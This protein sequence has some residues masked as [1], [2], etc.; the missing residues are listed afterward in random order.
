VR[1]TP[2][3][4]FAPSAA[5]DPAVNGGSGYFDGSGDSLSV[6]SNAAF[7]FGTGN[8]SIEVW[9]YPT[10]LPNA[11]QTIVTTCDNESNA[12]GIGIYARTTRELQ[13]FDFVSNTVLF[14]TSGYDLQLN[15]WT[16]IC[17]T[18]SG[19]TVTLYK[20]G[21]SFGTVTRTSNY[22][23]S[24]P[25]RIGMDENLQ[26]FF[27]YISNVRI[28][29]GSA[30]APTMSAPL[31]PITNTS[32]LCN[33]TNAGIFDN[34]GKNVLETVGNAQIDT[35]TK[36]FGTG[37]MEFDGTGDYLLVNTSTTDLYSFGAG[38]FTIECWLN[39]A[40]TQA[41]FGII[42]TYTGAAT[43]SGYVIRTSST[44]LRFIYRSG[45]STDNIIDRTVSLST[46]TWYHVAFVRSSGTY[47]VYVDGSLVGST[48]SLT[49]A[50]N[51][52]PSAP[53][54]LA[55]TGV[56]SEVFNGFID[57][58]RIT[59]GVARYPTEPFPTKAFPDL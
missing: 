47:A 37:S 10:S 23:A 6:A 9:V 55:A 43:T 7:N 31:T 38:D 32:L 3:S 14:D 20:N 44:G 54:V 58:L 42:S 40:A 52:N 28:I 49:A 39:L 1:V 24:T 15:A 35:T 21:S 25:T 46:G 16:N 13:V 22:S 59:K 51:A 29:K 5:Y 41:S 48:A 57:D 2:F 8:F 19:S 18:R 12:G 26:H 56:N 34:T 33:F 36:K 30:Q 53:I 27:G 45:S 4:P 50:I 17:L 11:F